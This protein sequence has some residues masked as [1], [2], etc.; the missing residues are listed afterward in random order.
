VKVLNV[1]TDTDRRG[2]QVFA[3]DLAEAMGRRGHDVDTV[4]LA[5]GKS[6]TRLDV[7]VLG[8]TR[9][10][11]ATLRALHQSMR[12][13]DVTV[14]HGSSAGP[15]CAI[16]ALPTQP[17][18]YRQIS[19]SAFW[20]NT[21]PKRV[22]VAAMLRSARC[23]VA[24][25]EVA[26]SKLIEHV[27][28]PADR[29]EVIPNG[30]PRG[31]FQPATTAKRARARQHFGIAA[32]DFVVGYVGA[33]V[34]EKGVADAIA[35]VE[36]L[37]DVQ[38]LVTG[39]GPQLTQLQ[40]FAANLES[41][42]TFTGPATDVSLTLHALDVAVLPS[43]SEGM[44]ASLIEAGFCGLPAIAT[45]IGS[46][47]EIVVDGHTGLLIPPGDVQA[48]T[49]AIT[50][51]YDDPQLRTTLGAAAERH[52]IDRFEMTVVTDQWLSMLDR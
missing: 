41:R 19:D 30:V 9:F 27:W 5:P 21:W 8:P 35:A 24:L 42:V 32:T 38:L 20:A 15:A 40:A 16:A 3:T 18:V 34:P 23:V 33:L 52:C 29:I 36:Q 7:Q 39:D 17:F 37:P 51:L 26:K 13:V 49:G 12:G 10:S 28:A 22:R 48:L 47:S 1:I 50:R 45:G 25:S 6:E 31:S 11:R 44:P 46:V 43:R 4:A 2:A 14:A